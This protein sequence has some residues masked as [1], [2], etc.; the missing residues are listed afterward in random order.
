MLEK[1]KNNNIK[2]D[3]SDYKNYSSYLLISKEA[4]VNNYLFYTKF[5]AEVSVAL[6]ANAYGL[7]AEVIGKVLEKVGCRKFFV[8]NLDEGIKLRSVVSGDIYVLGGYNSSEYFKYINFR[9]YPVVH[10][11]SVDYD[12][13]IHLPHLFHVD[14]GMRRIGMQI[15]EIISPHKSCHGI[16]SHLA[17]SAQRDHSMN[18][19]QL[20]L[21]NSVCDSFD[22]KSLGNSHTPIL[23]DSFFKSMIRIGGGLY[24]CISGLPLKLALTWKAKVIQ[25]FD[26]NKGDGIGYDHFYTSDKK[27]KVACV[28]VGYADGYSRSFSNKAYMLFNNKKLP[29]IGKVSMDL[30][31]IDMSESKDIKVGDY[32]DLIN[33]N[34]TPMMLAEISEATSPYEILCRISPRVKRIYI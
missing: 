27:R 2:T 17:F 34:L 12:S 8:A 7:G 15:S 22:I 25:I 33:N 3:D 29:V 19:I 23:G 10:D 13:L 6:K 4:I 18:H 20:S 32:V 26:I 1:D 24:G 9:L 14:T 28:A 16:I 30:T 21:F 11:I 5:S 31:T